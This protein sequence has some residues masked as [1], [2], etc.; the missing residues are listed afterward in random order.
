MFDTDTLNEIDTFG[1]GNAYV[2]TPEKCRAYIKNT[3]KS[4]NL[5]HL[6]IRSVNSNFDKFTVFLIGLEVSCD[7][8][9]LSEC[10][11]NPNSIIPVLEGYVSYHTSN[12]KNQ[13][14]GV[15]I[16]IKTGL[17]H[18]TT[19]PIMPDASCLVCHLKQYELSIVA[20]YRS[21][22]CRNQENFLDGLNGILASISNYKN[23]VVMGDI[24][25]DIT[26]DNL[27]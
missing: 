9:I 3:P 6:N 20:L 26:T 16:Y 13:N 27:N 23:V 1:R 21:P 4:L 15:I 25:I 2:C 14:D 19:E 24:N 7:I 5:I 10:W 17:L 22:S 18:N 12:P 8:I 11:L